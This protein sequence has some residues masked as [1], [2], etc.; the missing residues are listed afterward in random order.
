MNGLTRST[1]SL[2]QMHSSFSSSLHW[3]PTGNMSMPEAV[4]SAVRSHCPWNFWRETVF[5]GHA[6]KTLLWG[7]LQY[8]F[9]LGWK[10][11]G[12]LLYIKLY[13]LVRSYTLG[14]KELDSIL[15]MTYFWR[16]NLETWVMHTIKILE[17]GIWFI[18]FPIF[19]CSQKWGSEG[20]R[21]YK[22]KVFDSINSVI[23]RGCWIQ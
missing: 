18:I 21:L 1:S 9:F 5:C 13:S 12:P 19:H 22:K 8:N 11:N 23:V 10:E 15:L 16:F 2:C 3:I 14:M 7:F 4:S 6:K 17:S 20:T